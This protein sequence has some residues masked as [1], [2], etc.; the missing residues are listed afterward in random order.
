MIYH[1]FLR[2]RDKNLLDHDFS[3][4]SQQI[5]VATRYLQIVEKKKVKKKDKLIVSSLVIYNF[6]KQKSR[7]KQSWG[8]FC[9][10]ISQL[11]DTCIMM[12]IALCNTKLL[13]F[14]YMLNR[15]DFKT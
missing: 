5:F 4:I 3:V 6:P 12:Q 7:R 14:I 15:N 8:V 10:I 1:L 2:W 9:I 13:S 11:D